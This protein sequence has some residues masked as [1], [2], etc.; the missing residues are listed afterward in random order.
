MGRQP[1]RLTRRGRVV[2]N[3]A[4]CIGVLVVIMLIGIAGYVEGL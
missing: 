1:I 4:A 2:A 3:I